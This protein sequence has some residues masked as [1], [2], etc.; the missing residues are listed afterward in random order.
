MN[1]IEDSFY[2]VFLDV[3]FAQF[4]LYFVLFYKAH[5]EDFSDQAIPSGKQIESPKTSTSSLSPSVPGKQLLE[6]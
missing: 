2:E 3:I 4:K 6:K 1:S 5:P